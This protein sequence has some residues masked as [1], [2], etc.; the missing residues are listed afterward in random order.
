M[1][2]QIRA[3]YTADYKAQ[4]VSLAVSVL[5]IVKL[6]TA[7]ARGSGREQ[8]P[9]I[10]ITF[11]CQSPCRLGARLPA[12]YSLRSFVVVLQARN[13]GLAVKSQPDFTSLRTA[14]VPGRSIGINANRADASCV[15]VVDQSYI[16]RIRPVSEVPTT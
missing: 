15:D 8:L 13:R 11:F 1:A 7:D 14:L 5:D 12:E 4:A 9:G 6:P 10:L 3:Q 16:H 2:R